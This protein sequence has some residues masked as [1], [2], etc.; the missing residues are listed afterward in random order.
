MYK[1][2]VGW[3]NKHGRLRS[4]II[5]FSNREEKIISKKN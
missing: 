4:A 2:V 3:R 1:I 5:F